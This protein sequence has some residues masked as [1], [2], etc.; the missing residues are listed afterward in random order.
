[1]TTKQPH[2][3]VAQSAGCGRA[4]PAAR[5][6]GVAQK[7]AHKHTT[8]GSKKGRKKERRIFNILASFWHRRVMRAARFGLRRRRRR[9]WRRKRRRRARLRKSR[10]RRSGHSK[11]GAQ[12]KRLPKTTRDNDEQRDT[13]AALRAQQR[14][15]LAHLHTCLLAAPNWRPL[16]YVRHFAW[17]PLSRVGRFGWLA[18]GLL[19][20][21]S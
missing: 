10:S 7:P 5:L 20:D 14:A 12:F 16:G 9:R 15:E 3:L 17:A 1:M 2:R 8:R 6:V 19:S 11:E 21:K 4:R 13:R 18:P